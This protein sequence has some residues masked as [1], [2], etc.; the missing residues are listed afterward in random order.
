VE[1]TLSSCKMLEGRLDLQIKAAGAAGYSTQVPSDLNLPGI[2]SEAAVAAMGSRAGG[3]LRLVV[4]K[5]LE[6]QRLGLDFEG[7]RV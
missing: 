2:S 5:I 4:M 6:P 7:A 3:G 1:I